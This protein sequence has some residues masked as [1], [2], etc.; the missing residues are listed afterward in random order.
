MK[1]PD[2]NQPIRIVMIIIWIVMIITPVLS[3]VPVARDWSTV[4]NAFKAS[5]HTTGPACV[6]FFLNYLL[7]I[8]KFFFGDGNAI[9]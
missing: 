1:K 7:L 5:L 3:S 6:L 2:L 9:G 4:L 8:P